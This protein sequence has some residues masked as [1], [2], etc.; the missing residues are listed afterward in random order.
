MSCD[1]LPS[2]GPI[3]FIHVV[4]GKNAHVIGRHITCPSGKSGISRGLYGYSLRKEGWHSRSRKKSFWNEICNSLIWIHLHHR[5]TWLDVCFLSVW[6]HSWAWIFF[7]RTKHKETVWYQSSFCQFRTYKGIKG[8]RTCIP[9]LMIKPTLIDCAC[10][11]WSGRRVDQ[12][13]SMIVLV[14][15][16]AEGELANRVN[17]YKF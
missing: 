16:G 17:F 5:Q 14:D 15:G 6:S 9:S 2:L 8:R 13:A 7:C 12:S 3:I 1:P 4:L 10:W 11:R